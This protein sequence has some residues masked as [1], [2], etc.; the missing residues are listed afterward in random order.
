M[1]FANIIFGDSYDDKNTLGKF[2]EIIGYDKNKHL[3]RASS[4]LG[5]DDYKKDVLK[6][7]YI[8]KGLGSW[9]KA[10]VTSKLRS[11]MNSHLLRTVASAFDQGE[12]KN[13][14]K[15]DICD[16]AEHLGNADPLVISKAQY[17]AKYAFMAYNVPMVEI[18]IPVWCQ[19][20]ANTY[21]Y[22][23]LF[24]PHVISNLHI[25]IP[26]D[27][28]HHQDILIMFSGSFSLPALI[29]DL[30]TN[31]TDWDS[32]N[33]NHGK[34]NSYFL[35]ITKLINV[36]IDRYITN[37]ILNSH[38]TIHIIGHS[39]GGV[40]SQYT[41]AHL[42]YRQLNEVGADVDNTIKVWSYGSFPFCNKEFQNYYNNDLK[43]KET[44]YNIFNGYDFAPKLFNKL[45]RRD[46]GDEMFSLGTKLMICS[47]NKTKLS[48][49]KK[50]GIDWGCQEKPSNSWR[51]V[52]WTGHDDEIN[53][54]EE[55]FQSQV[56]SV[57][58]K[59][60]WTTG[61]VA[62]I[63]KIYND[64]PTNLYD[65]IYESYRGGSGKT[66]YIVKSQIHLWK[67]LRNFKIG[68]KVVWRRTGDVGTILDVFYE[69]NKWDYKVQWDSSKNIRLIKEIDIKGY[70]ICDNN[71]TSVASHLTYMGISGISNAIQAG[72]PAIRSLYKNETTTWDCDSLQYYFDNYYVT[73]I[74][75]NFYNGTMIQLAGLWKN[76]EGNNRNGKVFGEEETG[77]IKRYLVKLDDGTELSVK[78]ENLVPLC[79]RKWRGVFYQIKTLVQKENWNGEDG[80]RCKY[81]DDFRP[82]LYWVSN[83]DLIN[84]VLD[85]KR[86]SIGDRVKLIDPVA[87]S[88]GEKVPLDSV[89]EVINIVLSSTCS[90][91]YR[92]IVYFDN[93][94]MLKLDS[95]ALAHEV[96]SQWSCM[97]PDPPK[98]GGNKTKKTKKTKKTIKNKK[99]KK[100]KKKSKKKNIYIKD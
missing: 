48:L 82:T 78:P 60:V 92:V 27:D 24:I 40:F 47:T 76:Y 41:G 39:L 34:V 89:G 62:K 96:E 17:L 83:K 18:G 26:I 71:W 53:I 32:T 5:E 28:D 86:F 72:M 11:V 44:T 56:Y 98:H 15:Y 64:H 85:G 84:C 25:V 8:I 87:G 6:F 45:P 42:R 61:D 73:A 43:M 35:K 33:T 3:S 51:L 50:P 80:W 2:W 81:A 97:Y 88:A 20:I 38:R 12:L 46:G 54:G 79:G 4:I 49:T 7:A 74:K 55:Y 22:I 95:D 14:Y 66:Y 99:N 94:E 69:E 59:V 75:S 70:T 58:D 9:D 10:S 23:G 67:N 77:R 21:K 57:G 30:D 91:V 52:S 29:Q 16:G 31:T 68:D 13:P 63:T 1:E 36:I 90:G 93:G 37:D 19:D 100:N 65:V